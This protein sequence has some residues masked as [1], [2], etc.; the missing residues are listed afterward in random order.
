MAHFQWSPRNALRENW[1]DL[2][3]LRTLEQYE[4]AKL[5]NRLV[6]SPHNGQQTITG[7]TGAFRG[8]ARAISWATGMWDSQRKGEAILVDFQCA[9]LGF[10]RGP[11]HA[12]SSNHTRPG[13]VLKSLTAFCPVYSYLNLTSQILR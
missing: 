5:M 9:N 12:G 7:L 4:G 1:K 11:R 3:L 13:L 2:K 10:Q 8:N 6:E